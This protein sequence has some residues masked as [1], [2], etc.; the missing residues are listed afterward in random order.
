MAVDIQSQ[1]V[2]L[3]IYKTQDHNH[4]LIIRSVR[5]I[6]AGEKIEMWFSEEIAAFISVPFLTPKNIKGNL[7]QSH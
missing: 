7:L 2:T 3:D 6:N 5:N 4:G 1:N